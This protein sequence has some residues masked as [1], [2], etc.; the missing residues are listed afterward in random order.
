M[1]REWTA[2]LSVSL[3]IN[4]GHPFA[5]SLIERQK[6]GMRTD[7]CED[8]NE[9]V[10]GGT[11]RRYECETER[12]AKAERKTTRFKTERETTCFKAERE[13]NVKLKV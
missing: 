1:V 8:M 4:V 11:G 5:D 3:C 7:G 2:A 9:N 10:R 12:V 6:E 13:K